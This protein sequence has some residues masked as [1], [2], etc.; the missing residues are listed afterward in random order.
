[1]TSSCGV[2][3]SEREGGEGER[4]RHT[5]TDRGETEGDRGR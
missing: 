4:E 5:H 2:R 3:G 1:M